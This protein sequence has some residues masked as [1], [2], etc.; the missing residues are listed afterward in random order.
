M[1]HRKLQRG[2]REGY[3]E[4]LMKMQLLISPRDSSRVRHKGFP[5][6][7]LDPLLRLSDCHVEKLH[8]GL[9]GICSQ[10]QDHTTVLI[11]I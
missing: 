3:D 8:S 7:D 6:G 5:L 11:N 2:G 10:G 4:A 9:A 1:T